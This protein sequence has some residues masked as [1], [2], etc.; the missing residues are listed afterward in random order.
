MV[1]GL[2]FLNEIYF[3]HWLFLSSAC[4]VCFQ[5]WFVLLCFFFVLAYFFPCQSQPQGSHAFASAFASL[6]NSSSSTDLLFNFQASNHSPEIFPEFPLRARPHAH[7]H[8]PFS[9]HHVSGVRKGT[10]DNS[11]IAA[12]RS[13]APPDLMP[14]FPFH[15]EGEPAFLLYL[16]G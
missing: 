11:S 1:S 2:F 3:G 14:S 13:N 10:V 12:G 5:G 15:P 8:P 9:A 7:T 16:R 6:S 4:E